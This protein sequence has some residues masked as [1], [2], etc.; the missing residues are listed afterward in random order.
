[1]NVLSLDP[2]SNQ[3]PAAL[4]GFLEQCQAMAVR[5]RRAQL[6]SISLE[7]AN[8]DPLAVLESIFE[9]GERHFYVERP[10][11]NLAVAGAEAVL[12][13]TAS[14]AGRFAACQQ[15]IDGVLG[16]SI[17]VGDQGLP[18]AGPHF[19]TALT[20]A[21]KIEAG[22]PFDAATVFVPRWQVARKCQKT[23]A[24]ANLLVDATT[25]IALLAEKVW[26]A[27]QKFGAFK[28]AESIGS[29]RA[30][31]AKATMSEATEPGFYVKS[32]QRAVERI[33]AG[34]F[35]KIV[36]ARAKDFQAAETLHPL[37][38]LN[39][40]RERF[41]DCYAF[42]V[43]NGQGQSFI[44][45][46]PERLLRVNG[47]LL[48]TEALAGSAPRGAT[49]EEDTA[50]AEGLLRSDKDLHEHRIVL[51]SIA[52]R[53]SPL[54]VAVEAPGQPG[55]LRLANVQHLHTPVKA[56]L[57]VGVRLLDVLAQLHPTPAVGGTPRSAA[58]PHIREHEAFP[59]GL[60]A[61]AIGWIDSRGGGEFFV[62]LRSAL[63]EGSKAR[64]Y[65]GA[66]IVAGSSPEKELAETELKFK[67]ME[68]ALLAP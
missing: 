21:N 52:R 32:V 17:V 40:L 68:E 23:V 28:Y 25:P 64:L 3:T 50:L 8:L 36:L 59:R 56:A 13:F 9:P 42:S 14:G 51:D 22:E 6:V 33:K 53:L 47:G 29:Q 39:G 55:L 49:P 54:G 31:G 43:A 7:V 27:H 57:P 10:T 58:V 63:I 44:G 61:G 46:S 26:R 30:G 11:S 16:S 67:A 19:F 20:F 60:Y 1:M 62:G 24:V 48:T 65:A 4:L 12:S 15:F 66:G 2:A 5:M 41:K 45:A 35:Q 38:M 37:R 34:E 18:F